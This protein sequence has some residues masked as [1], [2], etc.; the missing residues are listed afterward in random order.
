[1]IPAHREKVMVPFF[2][3]TPAEWTRIKDKPY[4]AAGSIGFV[5]G[6][7]AD[8]LILQPTLACMLAGDKCVNPPG[9]SRA[10][11]C[12]EQSAMTLLIRRHYFGWVQ[13]LNFAYL[14]AAYACPAQLAC[15]S[16]PLFCPMRI[17]NKLA[18]IPA[19]RLVLY[20]MPSLSMQLLH[21]Q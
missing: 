5:L 7:D 18:C 21:P 16:L 8:R 3:V 14:I 1:M 6:S 9:H 11:F 2:N 4:C 20:M 15:S 13:S 19:C 17:L 12:Y 10:N